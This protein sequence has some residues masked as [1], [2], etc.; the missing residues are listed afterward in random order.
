MLFLLSG[1][2]FALLNRLDKIFYYLIR[3]RLFGDSFS[4]FEKVRLILSIRDH[5]L[6]AHFLFLLLSFSLMLT[7]LVQLSGGEFLCFPVSSI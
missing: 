2:W 1:A 7:F 6:L 4:Q 3:M 5:V